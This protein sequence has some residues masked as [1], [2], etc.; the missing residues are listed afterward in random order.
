MIF[1]GLVYAAFLWHRISK[2]DAQ[3]N[4]NASD[5]LLMRIWIVVFFLYPEIYI[6]ISINLN[7]V[8]DILE[9]IRFWDTNL[10]VKIFH[11]GFICIQAVA[12][13]WVLVFEGSKKLV[14]YDEEL[15]L[16]LNKGMSIDPEAK[17][18]LISI[19]VM[20]M[21]LGFYIVTWNFLR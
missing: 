8:K 13:L 15:A 16:R 11:I 21:Y 4:R 12:L 20:L 10:W 3:N 1:T 18:K 19:R 17:V 7:G 2:G 14:I 5:S 6:G 9:Y